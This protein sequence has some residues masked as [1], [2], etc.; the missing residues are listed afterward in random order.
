MPTYQ[1]RCPACGHEF[2]KFEK[3]NAAGRAKCPRCGKPAQ[4]QISGGAG[5]LFKGSGFYITD[6]KRKGQ[7]KESEGSDKPATSSKPDKKPSPKSP[8]AE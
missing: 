5:F 8:G 4:R 2:E 7:H 3:M 1:Y 6:Y